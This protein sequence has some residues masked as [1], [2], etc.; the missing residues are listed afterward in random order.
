MIKEN[1]VIYSPAERH[2]VYMLVT[3][4]F[5]ATVGRGVTLP[6]LP[7]FLH[8][9]LG[10]SIAG[11]GSSLTL[12]I[13]SGILLSIPF[14]KLANHINHKI[15]LNLSLLVFSFSFLFLGF[16]YSCF[17]FFTCFT[18]MTCCYSLYSTI[19]KCF[20]SDY[21]DD[22]EK[23]KVFSLNYTFI[24]I[25]WMVGPLIGSWLLG[26]HVYVSFVLSA[27]LGGLAIISTTGLKLRAH[28]T[29]RAVS[30][31]RTAIYRD[32]RMGILLVFTLAIFLASFVFERFASCISQIL[33][34][35]H[36]SEAVGK[37]VSILITTNAMTVVLFQY[38]TGNIVTKLS[39]TKGF[40]LGTLCLVAGLFIFSLAGENR[41][42]WMLG[43]FFFSFGEIIFAP[44]QYRVIDQISLPEGRAFYF[45]FQNLG[46]LGG[47]LNPAVTGMLLAFM[48]PRN[49]PWVLMMVSVL[50]FV[51]F[52][53]GLRL[54]RRFTYV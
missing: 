3:G 53:V 23:T 30:A 11:T 44:L 12:S 7:I 6:F 48:Q 50:C 20:I 25:G 29:I 43:M 24:N 34:V 17:V 2:N 37:I 16:F 5:F 18:L 31:Q 36:S 52:Y 4:S 33:M 19:I 45:S 26:Q 9:Q 10:L 32:R 42:T 15:L 54:S 22:E 51:V 14:G 41:M 47:A 28:P 27:L 21:F 39:A 49:V 46:S 13:I 8:R 40:M 1:S 38:I 35:D